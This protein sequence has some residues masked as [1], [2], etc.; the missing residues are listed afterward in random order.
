MVPG[1]RGQPHITIKDAS[2][3]LQEDKPEELTALIA[4]FIQRTPI[5]LDRVIRVGKGQEVSGNECFFMQTR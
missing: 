3:F 4:D 1:A 2:H 5:D